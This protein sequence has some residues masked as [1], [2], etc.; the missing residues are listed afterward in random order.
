VSD[1]QHAR[2]RERAAA[3]AAAG[4]KF[5]VYDEASAAAGWQ[6]NQFGPNHEYPNQF[7]CGWSCARCAR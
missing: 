3:A 1:C 7:L 4:H 5:T 6:A 2:C